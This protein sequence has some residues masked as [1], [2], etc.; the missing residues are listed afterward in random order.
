MQSEC[1]MAFVRTEII[2]HGAR[3]H[4]I[5]ER[6]SRY[7]HKY[8]KSTE[9]VKGNVGKDERNKM[10]S[11]IS[12]A[13]LINMPSDLE[14]I[15][16]GCDIIFQ[17]VLA[18]DSQGLQKAKEIKEK[19]NIPNITFVVGSIEENALD[20]PYIE[21]DE[22]EDIC[23]AFLDLLSIYTFP[24]EYGADFEELRPLFGHNG[25]ISTKK[26]NI[27]NLCVVRKTSKKSELFEPEKSDGTVILASRIGQE[28]KIQYYSI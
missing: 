11:S 27:F 26:G 19:Y 28:D 16:T 23:K 4:R 3:A 21:V 7:V 9:F 20:I 12:L 5:G 10:I 14:K 22:N 17:I 13:S 24:Q 2:C 8:L 6:L 1:I 18:G 25:K 15:D